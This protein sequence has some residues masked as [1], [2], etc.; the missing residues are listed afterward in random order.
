MNRLLLILLIS[1]SS[2]F[3]LSSCFPP[4]QGTLVAT[5]ETTSERDETPEQKNESVEKLL[6]VLNQSISFDSLK[7]YLEL[8][9]SSTLLNEYERSEDSIISS[10]SVSM[11]EIW[12]FIPSEKRDSFYE[13]DS[14]KAN[15]YSSHEKLHSFTHYLFISNDSSR[16]ELLIHGLT[17][18]KH[19]VITSIL[20]WNYIPSKHQT[21]VCDCVEQAFK[22]EELNLSDKDSKKEEDLLFQECKY[23]SYWQTK[24]SFQ[25]KVDTCKLHAEN[26]LPTVLSRVKSLIKIN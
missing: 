25:K 5:E 26:E 1:G 4:R 13:I 2:V 14:L 12:T 16:L 23:M 7:I 22:L 11:N 10:I 24:T 3:L 15:S 18:F 9:Q 6:G 17:D 21:S 20:S 19:D 8:E